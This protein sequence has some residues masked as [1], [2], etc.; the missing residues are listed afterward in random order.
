[1]V[2]AAAVGQLVV[3]A[4]AAAAMQATAVTAT[5][6]AG[7]PAGLERRLRLSTQAARLR[8]S[9]ARLRAFVQ[10][11]RRTHRLHLGEG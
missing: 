1:V 7:Q 5:F 3:V 2:A 10:R 8:H 6:S 11:F 4:V 9:F